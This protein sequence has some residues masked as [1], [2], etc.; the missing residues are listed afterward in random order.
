M[1][2]KRYLWVCDA[3]TAVGQGTV[4][5]QKKIS[6]CISGQ[7]WVLQHALYITRAWSQRGCQ[8]YSSL[9]GRN[10]PHANCGSQSCS[11][12]V[13]VCVCVCVWTLQDHQMKRC[14]IGWACSTQRKIKYTQKS[15]TEI[16]KGRKKSRWARAWNMA[17][18]SHRKS[19]SAGT[20]S[21]SCHAQGHYNRDTCNI[22]WLL[23]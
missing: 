23:H 2:G 5:N 17:Y 6:L 7:P 8:Q 3:V 9:Q 21:D 19:A 1:E 13:C 16:L 22:T 20:Y 18:L 11:C 12:P 14:D 15:L 4:G 10:M